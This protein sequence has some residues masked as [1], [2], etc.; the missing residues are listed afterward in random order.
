MKNSRNEQ[1]YSE[2]LEVLKI[3]PAEDQ[4]LIPPE[5][6]KLIRENASNVKTKLK[7][8]RM[9]NP[10]ISEDTQAFITALFRK[11]I[12]SEDKRNFFDKNLKKMEAQD[13]IRKKE[14]FA[15]EHGEYVKFDSNNM[16][17]ESK[18]EENKSLEVLKEE[19]FLKKIFY[20]FKVFFL[21]NK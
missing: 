9:G 16:V 19:G 18:N 7:V 10:I 1:M 17:I 3:I 2:C 13:E 21:K 12:M 5:T 8:D 20:K 11:Y 14:K 6:I 4:K 15:K